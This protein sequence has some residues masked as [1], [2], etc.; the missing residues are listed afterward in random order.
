[1]LED[2]NE[3]SGIVGMLV[4]LI[5]LV[6]AGAFFSLVIDKRFKLSSS[7][8][9]VEEDVAKEALV[10][11]SLRDELSL[12]RERWEKATAPLEGQP[13]ALAEWSARAAATSERLPDLRERRDGL[14]NEVEAATKAYLDYRN[15]YRA[16]VRGDAAGEKLVRLETVGGKVYSDVSIRR[17]TSAGIE[18][19]HAHGPARLLP[20]DLG[21]E[22]NERFQWDQEEVEMVLEQERRREEMHRKA[23]ERSRERS[24]PQ[25]PP[26][27]RAPGKKPAAG[28][29]NLRLAGLRDEVIAARSLMDQ[30]ADELS[31]ARMEALNSRGR[32]VPGS[33]E[34]WESKISQLQGNYDKRRRGYDSACG[35]LA[36]VAPKDALL[37]RE[38]A[39]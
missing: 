27:K 8:V 6:L 39:P 16:Q 14:E 1:M 4:G 25:E 38:P 20:K 7:R 21:P 28:A 17:V 22:W 31:R 5:V 30:A 3:S 32:S 11:E 24:A 33:L 37:R 29:S 9:S 12:K 19:T 26:A 2:S 35:R 13:A 36:T 15:S 18:F 34:T 10:V 23:I